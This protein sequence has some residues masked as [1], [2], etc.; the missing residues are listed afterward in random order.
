[1]IFNTFESL[2]KVYIV[3]IWFL[4]MC[5]SSPLRFALLLSI[6]CLFCIIEVLVMLGALHL[7]FCAH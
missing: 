5:L 2:N 4:K 3:S 1:M 7:S 6:I